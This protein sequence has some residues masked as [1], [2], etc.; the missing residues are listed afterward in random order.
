MKFLTP[1]QRI[2]NPVWLREQIPALIEDCNDSIKRAETLADRAHADEDKRA[3]HLARAEG[4]LY[5]REQLWRILR[6]EE[7][8]RQKREGT[9]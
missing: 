4:H 9:P 2:T 1:A 5:W 8:L 3:R 7:A 6:G